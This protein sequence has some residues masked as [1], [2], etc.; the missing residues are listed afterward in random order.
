MKGNASTICEILDGNQKRFVIPVYQRKYSWKQN[1]CKQ[2]FNDLVTV[3]KEHRN[4][5]FFGSIVSANESGAHSTYIIIDGQQRITTISLLLL[6]MADLLDNGELKSKEKNLSSDIRDSY[7]KST[8]KNIIKLKLTEEDSP[9]YENLFEK[10]KD[11]QYNK[12]DLFGNYNYF[13]SRLRE[14]NISIDELYDAVKNLEVID[15]VLQEG[16]DAQLIFESLNSTGLRLSESDKIRNYILMN[17]SEADQNKFYKNYWQ[18]ILK[19]TKDGTD[20][21]IRDYLSVK[22]LVTPIIW[23]IY[24]PFKEYAADKPTEEL[25]SDMTG[26]VKR[27]H[28]LLGEKNTGSKK[29]DKT[30]RRLN[31]MGT[32]V[33]RPFLL[34]V[35]RLNEEGVL[36][37]EETEKIFDLVESYVF[38][39]AVCNIAA[40]SM[41]K[42]FLRL[43]YEI[44]SLDGTTDR[45][46]DKFK[47]VMLQKQSYSAHF[48]KDG[49]FIREF[50]TRDMFN[51]NRCAYALERLETYRSLEAADNI[52]NRIGKDFSI[53]HIMPRT[54]SPEWVKELGPDYER[55]HEEWV[56]RIGN[57]TLTGYNSQMSNLSFQTKKKNGYKD[58]AFLLN[59]FVTEQETWDEDVMKER[60]ELLMK[61]ALDIWR[62]PET[63]YEP[64]EKYLESFTLGNEDFY[65]TGK[66]IAKFSFQGQEETVSSWIDMYLRVVR[67]LYSKDPSIL[68]EAALHPEE[69]KNLKGYFGTQ[70]GYF[71]EE[72]ALSDTILAE[73]H[74]TNVEKMNVLRRVF[75]LYGED[76]E[77]LVFYLASD[78]GSEVDDKDSNYRQYWELALPRIKEQFP[79]PDELFKLSKASHSRSKDSNTG[80]K[81]IGL[82]VRSR[83][84]WCSVSLYLG[85]GKEENEA[86][87][88]WLFKRKEEIEN[89][90]GAA[91]IWKRLNNNNAS[92]ISFECHDFGVSTPERWPEMAEFHAENSRRLF[93]TFMPYLRE[94]FKNEV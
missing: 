12:S 29:L 43:H 47:Y 92:T 87:F 2:L 54:L 11:E 89:K 91:L 40:N 6:A 30:I 52:L 20:W 76:P 9:A 73:R 62:Y 8:S 86:L 90:F 31:Y 61:K 21:F 83:P 75:K 85:R 3:V 53:E 46:F 28:K 41:N 94:Y 78:E 64:E 1:N 36:S 69:Y 26:Y 38:R 57:L 7:L 80:I 70:K 23:N 13:V 58:S 33:T 17:K 32:G 4:S 93:D 24:Q 15:I 66:K 22:T 50:S 44:V 63:T 74:L 42:T 5:H 84:D 60:T 55:V 51:T 82:V 65:A 77:D 10:D 71:I 59:H 48:P 67:I 56:N 19:V 81:G 18:T 49:E 79:E 88:D 39:R 37:M 25:L 68:T 14:M 34:E 16:D 45:Y 27:Y 72:F 35:L